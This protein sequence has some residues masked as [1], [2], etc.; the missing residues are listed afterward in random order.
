MLKKDITLTVPPSICVGSPLSYTLGQLQ[1]NPYP[2]YWQYNYYFVKWEYEDGTQFNGW[3]NAWNIVQFPTFSSS[4]SQP[5]ASKQK[6][7]VILNSVQFNCPDTSNFAPI[8]VLG[9][10]AA[11]EIVNDKVCFNT[12]V[13]FRDVSVV[14]GSNIVRRTWDFGDGRVQTSTGTTIS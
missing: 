13:N 11:L 2:D 7:R 5:D 1:D 14:A 3:N 4:I 12:P 9:P 6:I 10:Q 8:Q